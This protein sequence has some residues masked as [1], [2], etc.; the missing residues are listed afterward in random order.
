M[1][2]NMDR[3]GMGFKCK[4]TATPEQYNQHHS[5]YNMQAFLV[6]Q[7][8]VGHSSNNGNGQTNGSTSGSQSGPNAGTPNANGG[9]SPGSSPSSGSTSGGSQGQRR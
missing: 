7:T 4:S 3:D 5:I 1:H 6:P 8:V 2:I 9:G